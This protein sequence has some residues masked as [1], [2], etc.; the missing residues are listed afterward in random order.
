MGAD[1]G[2]MIYGK[3]LR[4]ENF[5]PNIPE[6]RVDVVTG[7][8]IFTGHA[9]LR[10]EMPAASLRPYPDGLIGFNYLFA[11]TDVRDRDDQ[12]DDIASETNF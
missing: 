11:Q 5:N 8:N 2:I 3:D 6:V 7:Y 9:F 12:C 10:F 4:T 1:P